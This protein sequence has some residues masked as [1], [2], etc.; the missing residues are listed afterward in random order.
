VTDNTI[1]PEEVASRVVD[2]L[3]DEI[4]SD[5]PLTRYL[6][7]IAVGEI[8]RDTLKKQ[9]L[10]ERV[11]L[12]IR[13]ACYKRDMFTCQYCGAKEQLTL[14]HVVP[15]ASGG[16]SAMTNLVTCCWPCNIG[17]GS[18]PLGEELE[19]EILGRIAA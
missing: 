19:A 5:H 18:E 1:T 9:E 13:F 15:R 3:F 11:P 12:K 6:L 17:K 4:I 8:A 16:S 14:D 7:E 10:R 2:T